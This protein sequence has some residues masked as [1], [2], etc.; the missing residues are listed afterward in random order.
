MAWGRSTIQSAAL[1][2]VEAIPVDVEVAVSRGLPGFFIVGLVDAAVQ[3]SKERVRAA[4]RESGFTMPNDRVLVNLAPSSLRKTGSGFDLAIAMGILV[5]TGQVSPESARHRLFVGEV[6]L[7]G[8]VRP[9]TGL[10][11]YALCARDL[12]YSLVCSEDADGLIPVEGLESLGMR[13]LVELREGEYRPIDH[14][15]PADAES[16]LDYGDIAGNDLG[17]RAMQIAAAG[18]HGVLMMGP[19]GSGKTMLASRLPSIMPPLRED[20]LLRA[21][22]IH[23]VAGEDVSGILA[24]KRPFRS[25]HHSATAPGL[26]GGGNPVRPGEVSLA[27]GGVL[28]LDELPEFRGS[29]LQQIRQPL[30]SGVVNISRADGTVSFPARFMLVA[31][32]NPCPCGFFGDPERACSC[33]QRQVAKYQNRIGGPLIDRIDL[34]ID[35]QRVPPGAVISSQKGTTSADLRVGVMAAREYAAWRRAQ[36]G[37]GDSSRNYLAECRLSDED[38][39]F[40]EE[41]AKLNHMSGRAIVRTMSVARTIADMDCRPRVSRDDLCEA[42]GFR[43]R[44]GVGQ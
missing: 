12:G 14:Y 22:L 35:V 18:A 34:H 5:A 21:A 8:T 9:V 40:F 25:P 33:T 16:K 7:N 10:L 13:S 19:P 39:R 4:L 17:K 44:E 1:H 38:A 30:E 42:L 28:F 24:G 3:E 23:S 41:M 32:S 43:L 31:A 2:G 29:V 6:S 20:E 27:D 36:D 15:A 37:P 26:I 11:A